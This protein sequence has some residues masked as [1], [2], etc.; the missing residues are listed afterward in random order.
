MVLER[1]DLNK[2]V[3][4]IEKYENYINDFNK[5]IEELNILRKTVLEKYL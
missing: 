2:I 5:Q 3:E 1:L 4:D